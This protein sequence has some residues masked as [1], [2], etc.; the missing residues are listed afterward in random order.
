LRATLSGRGPKQAALFSPD[1]YGKRL[2]ELYA[3]L[4]VRLG[5]A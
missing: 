3:K 4:G 1:A 2:V 5:E